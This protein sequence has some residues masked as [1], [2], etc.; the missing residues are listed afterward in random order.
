[1]VEMKTLE[2]SYLSVQPLSGLLSLFRVLAVGKL[3]AALSQKTFLCGRLQW[4]TE[5]HAN[6]GS[7]SLEEVDL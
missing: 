6:E 2:T 3:I 1:M 4:N 5:E 7:I